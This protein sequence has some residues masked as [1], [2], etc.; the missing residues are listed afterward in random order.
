MTA[1][2]P[3]LIK[4]GIGAALLIAGLGLVLVW[5]TFAALYVPQCSTFSIN[6]TDAHCRNP[7][8]WLY[9]GYVLAVLG[10]VVIGYQVI[11]VLRHRLSQ[12]R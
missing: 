1:G 11:G 6:A 9:A 10:A 7:V 5:G 3:R 2:K 8:L 4:L 12:S